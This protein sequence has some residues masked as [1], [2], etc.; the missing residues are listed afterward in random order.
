MNKPTWRKPS[1][2]PVSC[3]EKIKVLNENYDEL[4]TLAQEALDDALL[5]GCSE[6]QMRAIL[7]Q[8]I[9]NL[10]ASYDELPD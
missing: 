5:M 8:M 6:Q 2:A 10:R 4:R 7:R 9:D 1:G 3:T